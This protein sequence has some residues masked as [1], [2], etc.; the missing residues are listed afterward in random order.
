VGTI[1]TDG[2]VRSEEPTN[3]VPDDLNQ[4]DDPQIDEDAEDSA[5][6]DELD[7][8]ESSASDATA[9]E[10]GA[11]D[12]EALTQA[13]PND[14]DEEEPA[15]EGPAEQPKAAAADPFANATPEQKAAWQEA[16]AKIAK[17]D[18]SDRS[19]RGR[20]GAMQRRINEL[21]AKS[22]AGSPTTAP[23]D[24]KKAAKPTKDSYLESDE[25]KAFADEYPEV[26]GPFGKIVSSLEQRLAKHEERFSAEEQ[27]ELE[28]ALDEQVE[29]LTEQH[30]DWQEVLAADTPVFMEWLGT[31][32]RHIQEAAYRNAEVIVD[33]AE[34][35]DVYS[36]FKAFRSGNGAGDS[37]KTDAS[38]KGRS[39]GKPQLTGRRQ[40]QLESAAGARG[41]GPGVASGIPEDGDP[42]SLWDA[43]DRMEQRQAQRA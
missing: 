33:A 39:N 2:Q 30:P 10:S 38:G 35:A 36:R 13:D 40:R 27:A 34:A 14:P 26:A 8:E 32:P 21:M 18:Q 22:T 4:T 17:L 25:Y 9:P 1:E 41:T 28:S 29:L 3:D 24:G 15:S 37:S 5:L 42:Q 7:Q 43:F 23:A 16:Q 6:W 12:D 11:D 31:Q 19:N 20:L